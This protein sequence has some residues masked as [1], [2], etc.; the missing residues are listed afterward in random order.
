MEEYK[1]ITEAYTYFH[2]DTKQ[3]DISINV[4]KLF[5]MAGDSLWVPGGKEG[6]GSTSP[7]RITEIT[8]HLNEPDGDEADMDDLCIGFEKETWDVEK[9][10][11]IYTDTLFIADLKAF[12]IN[13]GF[14]EDAVD[15]ICYSEQGMQG[16]GYVSCDAE[17]FGKFLWELM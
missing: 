4:Q 5:R 11:L 10:G 12:L 14:P 3:K 17:S 6:K 13:A 15:D 2:S 8:M 7:V 16:E 1:R 9:Q